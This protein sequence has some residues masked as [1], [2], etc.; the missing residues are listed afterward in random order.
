MNQSTLQQIKILREQKL[1]YRSIATRLG[2][3]KT[4][5]EYHCSHSPRKQQ[6]LVNQRARRREFKL[7]LV[8]LFGGQCACGY[9]KSLAALDFH[10]KDPQS[11]TASISSIA[12][13]GGYSEKTFQKCVAEAKKCI[14]LCSNCHHEIHDN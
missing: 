9:K 13:R 2:I 8:N 3:S 6:F 5:V 14:L 10:H 1:S 11:K 4:T 12:S 7:R